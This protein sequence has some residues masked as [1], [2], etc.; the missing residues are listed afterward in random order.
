M[1]ALLDEV[2]EE[3]SSR[4][5]TSG[6]TD[7]DVVAN[8]GVLSQ[9]ED[10]ASVKVVGMEMRASCEGGKRWSRPESPVLPAAQPP[11]S[12]SAEPPQEIFL[13]G[14]L[15][16][17]SHLLVTD[18]ATEAQNINSEE[19]PAV[20]L[21]GKMTLS[22]ISLDSSENGTDESSNSGRKYEERSSSN[23]SEE[24][25]KIEADPLLEEEIDDII[26]KAKQI[27]LDQS[28]LDEIRKE[29]HEDRED[30]VDITENFG[31]KV[32][33]IIEPAGDVQLVENEAS[34]QIDDFLV[35]ERLQLAKENSLDIMN[36]SLEEKAMQGVATGSFQKEDTETEEQLPSGEVSH[37]EK[38][39]DNK[40]EEDAV[41]EEQLSPEE[42]SKPE[43]NI[44]ED[45]IHA[46]VT[47]ANK[48]NGLESV[49]KEEFA[50][51]E[52]K[53]V[54]KDEGSAPM[55]KDF[56]QEIG[57]VEKKEAIILEESEMNE[58]V[59]D[60]RVESALNTESGTIEKLELS[61][62][63]APEEVD[64]TVKEP[65]IVDELQQPLLED[66]SI[67]VNGASKNSLAEEETT[68]TKEK[69]D[70]ELKPEKVE[71][72][73]LPVSSSKENGTVD[74]LL[75]ESETKVAMKNPETVVESEKLVDTLLEQYSN[76]D[77][78]VDKLTENVTEAVEEPENVGKPSLELAS[79]ELNCTVGLPSESRAQVSEEKVNAGDDEE[80]V[81]DE[82]EE[83]EY[84]YEESDEEVD[85]VIR[86]AER[87][88][89]TAEV[90]ANGEKMNGGIHNGAK[91]GLRDDEDEV[92][93]VSCFT[94]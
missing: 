33:E 45:I 49:L 28:L 17:Q 21:A 3:L 52:Q 4:R 30:V 37:P 41:T 66:S 82:E 35:E 1:S 34:P 32:Q 94:I 42:V 48:D 44:L 7:Q 80:E 25:E 24:F 78:S 40:F 10:Q 60:V 29:L 79:T 50:E 6:G 88:G 67:R 11:V 12:D 22:V 47:E 54:E 87:S 63:E 18:S 31:E 27:G 62:P 77:G 15:P 74:E 23:V 86:N 64:E 59:N 71:K 75:T 19:D 93:E 20:V 70:T 39:V 90:I 91:N 13:E 14:A 8:G 83:V 51:L 68:V 85:E 16:P 38:K 72:S 43:G 55:T 65:G 81:D 5:K 26:D 69:H 76:K 92:S 46:E 58:P 9:D 84:E 56:E 36:Q 73:L 89:D 2:D 61:E 53:Q 57:E